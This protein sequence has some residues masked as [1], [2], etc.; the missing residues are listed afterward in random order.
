[1]LFR[2]VRFVPGPFFGFRRLRLFHLCS[3][4][5]QLLVVFRNLFIFLTRSA[6]PFLLLDMF[7]K[8]IYIDFVFY[9]C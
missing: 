4:P 7:E 1:M 6:P 9:T 3:E 5:Y 2:S 8:F